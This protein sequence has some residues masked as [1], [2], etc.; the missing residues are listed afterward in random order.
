M[1][2]LE[3]WDKV[4]APSLRTIAELAKQA[5]LRMQWAASGVRALPARPAFLTKAEAEL[6]DAEQAATEA[7]QLIRLAR[8]EYSKLNVIA[9]AAE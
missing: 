6:A 9:E 8:A 1:T 7:L 4:T 3:V 5:T 2:D